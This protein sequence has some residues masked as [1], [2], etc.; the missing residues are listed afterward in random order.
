MGTAGRKAPSL[1][2]WWISRNRLPSA[3]GA[4]LTNAAP[5]ARYAIQFRPTAT[6]LPEVSR[7]GERGANLD[8]D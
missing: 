8:S 2:D 3:K 1:Q 6:D 4:R 5:P 7:A